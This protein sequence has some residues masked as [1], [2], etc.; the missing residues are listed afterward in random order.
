MEQ[1]LLKIEME[2]QLPVIKADIHELSTQWDNNAQQLLIEVDDAELDTHDIR[3]MIR[4]L[5]CCWLSFTIGQARAL[6]LTNAMLQADSL[7]LF[8]MFYEGVNY[9]C[10]TNIQT[11]KIRKSAQAGDIPAESN[12]D[13]NQIINNAIITADLD[14]TTETYRF[15]NLVGNLMFSLPSSSGGTLLHNMLSNRDMPNQHPISAIDGLTAYIADNNVNIVNLQTDMQHKLGRVHT[16]NTMTGAG[17]EQDPLKVAGSI[18]ED[19]ATFIPAVDADSNISWT[20]NKGLPDPV[21]RNIRGL[22]GAKGEQG[23]RGPEGLRIQET[24]I[25]SQAVSIPEVIP[26]RYYN[27]TAEVTSLNVAAAQLSLDESVIEFTTGAAAPT[28]TF[29]ANIRWM[30]GAPLATAAN[31]RFV[32]SIRHGLAAYGRFAK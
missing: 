8:I 27:C 18:G 15:F 25:T 12:D 1:T 30:N 2:K 32:I 10:S 9:R 6:P 20:N 16:D 19:G 24:V 17:T 5:Q 29:P 13:I 7:E 21:T 22:P 31:M 3:V 26:N 4:P 11:F 23:E 14:T 28:I